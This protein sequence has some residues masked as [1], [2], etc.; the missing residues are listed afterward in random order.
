MLRPIACLS[1]LPMLLSFLSYALYAQEIETP[2]QENQIT[3]TGL[4]GKTFIIPGGDR[5][6]KM[7]V[8]V[9]DTIRKVLFQAI[10]DWQ[11]I[12]YP[13]EEVLRSMDSAFELAI[14]SGGYEQQ[15]FVGKKGKVSIIVQGSQD[16]IDSITNRKVR[17]DLDSV[18]G[19]EP[20]YEVHTH[21]Y[22]L[23]GEVI[24]YFSPDPSDTDRQA[25]NFRGRRQASVILSFER[26]KLPNFSTGNTASV[27]FGSGNTEDKFVYTRVIVFYNQKGTIF[28]Q[29]FS[30]FKTFVRLHAHE[31]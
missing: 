21:G 29:Y 12:D 23:A 14:A 9:P 26:K 28:K 22:S 30:D 16:R 17:V 11:V 4:S 20:A 27:P 25:T 1:I 31:N 24:P 7:I 18:K 15:F 5:S 2:K 10:R 13:S 6:K 8:L 19:D 3:Y